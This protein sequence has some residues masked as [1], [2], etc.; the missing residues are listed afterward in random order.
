MNSYKVLSKQVFSNKE[1]NIIPIRYEDRYDIMKWRNEQINILRQKTLLT[2][3][4][5]DAYFD[6]VVLSLFKAERPSQ[7]LFSYLR[8]EEVIGY[9]GLVHIDWKNRN[10]EISFLLNPSLNTIEFYNE[11]FENY[12][13]LIIEPA[14]NIELHK[15]YTY[16]YNISDY[17]F[18]PLINKNFILEATLK[19]QVLIE[20]RLVD[21]KIYAKIL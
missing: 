7:I 8:N 13:D 17:R 18:F 5:Q 15:I 2:E 4:M 19:E 3:E 14:K 9:G 21:V 11:A 12:L 1:F 20:E 16:G 6:K 10:A